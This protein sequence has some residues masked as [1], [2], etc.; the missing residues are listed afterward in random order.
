M[1]V[2]TVFL[3]SNPNRQQQKKARIKFRAFYKRVASSCPSLFVIDRSSF[4]SYL[5]FYA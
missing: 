5:N 4:L 2:D 3:N 1:L